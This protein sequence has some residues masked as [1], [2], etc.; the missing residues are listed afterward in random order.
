MINGKIK[1]LSNGREDAESKL[2]RLLRWLAR[3]AKLKIFK[4]LSLF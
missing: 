4:N 2:V 1:L 3:L